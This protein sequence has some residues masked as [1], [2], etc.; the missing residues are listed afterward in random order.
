M[1]RHGIGETLKGYLSSARTCGLIAVL[2]LPFGRMEAQRDPGPPPGHGAGAIVYMTPL[3]ISKQDIA[4][5]VDSN[6]NIRERGQSEV[7]WPLRIKPEQAC[8][9]GRASNAREK[10]PSVGVK[11]LSQH[12]LHV[13]IEANDSSAS[14]VGTLVT[15]T[16][17]SAVVAAHYLRVWRKEGGDW[18]VLFVCTSPIRP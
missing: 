7:E 5:V 13:S 16:P 10:Q 15:G 4:A 3:V 2:V 12:P 14:E 17:D 1:T 11:V 9:T 18:G 6:A 8:Q